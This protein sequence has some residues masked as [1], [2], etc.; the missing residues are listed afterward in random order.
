LKLYQQE[1]LKNLY[2]K[3]YG[4]GRAL[5]P[6]NRSAIAK[7]KNIVSLCAEVPHERII[8]I[9]AGEGAVIDRLSKLG[10][11]RDLYAIEITQGAINSIRSRSIINLKDALIFDGYKIP[12]QSK[13]FNIALISHVL[14]HVEHPRELLFEAGRV[15]DYVFVEVPLED[16]FRM[17]RNFQLTDVGHIN[18]F[19]YKTIRFLVQSCNFVVI[20]QEI[21]NPLSWA[22]FSF[23]STKWMIREMLLRS[24]PRIASYAT[25][26]NCSMLCQCNIGENG[27]CEM[28]G[29]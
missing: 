29:I 22:G 20:R 14:E 11:S 9:G 26:Y 4:F 28:K 25:T 6:R 17:A 10:F 19:S 15:A 8:D 27:L 16:N 5:E 18:Y 24:V 2:R 13:C 1:R 7:V 21:R 23:A 3:Q 12:F